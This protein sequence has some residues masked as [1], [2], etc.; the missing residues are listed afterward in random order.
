MKKKARQKLLKKKCIRCKKTIYPEREKAICLTTYFPS[1]SIVAKIGISIG[2]APPK[3]TEEW[4]HFQCWQDFFK[5]A[6]QIKVQALSKRAIGITKKV[7]NSLGIDKML[8]G[9]ME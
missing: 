2:T 8:Q 5:E 3:V 1:Q 9:V 4:F 6:V 7:F